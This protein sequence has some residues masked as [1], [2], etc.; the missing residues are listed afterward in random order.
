MTRI[1]LALLT[2]LILTGAARAAAADDPPGE[3]T[4]QQR[5][6]LEAKW[7]QQADAI[8]ELHQRGKLPEAADAARQALATARRLY[9]KQD[10]HNMAGSLNNLG[11]VLWGQGNYAQAEKVQREA[12]AMYRRLYPEQ[13]HPLLADSL[14][15]LAVLLNDQGKLA[16]SEKVHREALAMRRRLHAKQDHPRLAGSMVNLAN[17]LKGQGK[18]ADAESLQQEALAMRRRLYPDQDHRDLANSLTNLGLVLE[19]RARYADAETSARAALEMNRRL[20]PR[21]DHPLVAASLNNLALPL[22]HQRKLA[23]AEALQR[24]ALAM[25]RRLLRGQDQANLARMLN[26]LAGVLQDQQRHAEA[27]AFHREAVAMWRRLFRGQD[28]P[29]LAEGLTNLANA[30]KDREEY[31]EAEQL[32]HEALAIRRRVFGGQDHRDMAASLNNLGSVLGAARK[33]ADAEKRFAESVAMWRRLYPGQDHP[34]IAVSIFNLAKV[35]YEQQKH[36]A[37]AGLFRDALAMYRALARDYALARAEGEALTLAATYPAARDGF[38]SSARASKADAVHVYAEVWASKA[39]VSRVYEQRALAA[40]TAAADP[41]AAKLLDQLTDRRR[42]RADLLLTAAPA[43][44]ATAKE[45]DLALTRYADEIEAIDRELRPLLPTAA[46]GEKLAAVPADLQHVLPQGAVVVDYLRWVRYEPD[47]RVPGNRGAKAT[48]RY[49]AF[50]LTRDQLTW[51]DLGEAEPI[52][53]A[54]TAWRSAITAGKAIP[55]ELADK[56]RERIWVPVR[57]QLPAQVKQLYICPDVALCRVPWVALPG[58]RPNTILLEEYA[59]A[60]IPHAPF[61][62]DKLWP[63]DTR[64]RRPTELLAVG[65]VTYDAAAPTPEPLAGSRGD[66]LLKPGETL[67]WPSLPGAAAEVHGVRS[68][69]TN[70]GLACRTLDKDNA[71]RAA[72]LAALPKARHAHLATHGFFADPSFRS[73]FQLDPKLFAMSQRGERIGAGALSPMV[74]TGLVFAGANKPDTPGRGIVTGEAL[75]DLDLSGLELAVLS[76]CETGLGDVAGGEGTFGLQRAFHLAGT[77]DVIASLWKVPD[78]PTA[79]LMALF[80]RNLWAKEMAPVEALRQA[81]LEIYRHPERIAALADSFRGQ[82]SQVPGSK[83]TPAQAA[84]GKAHPRLWAAFT[85]SGPGR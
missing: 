63:T 2:A 14:N 77:R 17:V 23:D 50:V 66:P 75:V 31:A 38:L 18:L 6:D 76:A 58:D 59:I 85:L 33:Y 22:R 83:E 1:A 42:R 79:A 69:G 71:T 64:P 8:A 36:D 73:A 12:L 29:L 43:D 52:E 9:G 21:Q 47:P 35:L 70:K 39:V 37:A 81:Q 68:A 13:D 48:L 11:L 67:A 32:Q 4:A 15:N 60:T 7:R 61:L 84:D 55:P 3:L 46:R 49:L 72:V 27:E 51:L 30:L 57:R 82:F 56:V 44:P 54:I 41:R 28:H 74:M 80:Y 19:A 62:L 45:R 16:D 5:K 25:Y 26:N 24:E 10:H 65:G 20:Y 53:Q 78:R 34:E 40:R